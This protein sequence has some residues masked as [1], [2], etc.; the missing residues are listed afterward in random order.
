MAVSDMTMMVAAVGLDGERVLVSLGRLSPLILIGAVFPFPLS[1]S[2]EIAKH[3]KVAN[4][5]GEF[6]I[7][8][9]LPSPNA[10]F[11]KYELIAI[12]KLLTRLSKPGE[13][14]RGGIPFSR[15]WGP[16]N[17]AP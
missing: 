10:K 14:A 2:D 5:L 17:V 6:V 15:P 12:T 3:C 11:L 1:V 13:C 4:R 7:C 8:I 9:I 16:R